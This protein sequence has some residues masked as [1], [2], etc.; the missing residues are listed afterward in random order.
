MNGAKKSSGSSSATANTRMT[1]AA[2]VLHRAIIGAPRR[3]ESGRRRRP[4]RRGVAEG[5]RLRVVEAGRGALGAAVEALLQIGRGLDA[6]RARQRL[7]E[8]RQVAVGITGVGRLRGELGLVGQ[9]E[10]RLRLP[11]QRVDGRCGHAV[12][13]EV[14]KPVVRQIASTSA[15]IARR[16]TAEAASNRARSSAGKSMRRKLTCIAS[17]GMAPSDGRTP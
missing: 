17:K 4:D 6:L 9:R 14:E 15:P 16:P 10:E 13:D 11:P 8:R 7:G 2:S 5:E 1:R 12:A 3:L